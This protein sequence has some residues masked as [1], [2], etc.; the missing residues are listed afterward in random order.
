MKNFYERSTKYILGA[1]S[2]NDETII[3]ANWVDIKDRCHAKADSVLHFV[4]KF[5]HILNFTEDQLN[6]FSEEFIDYAC[7]S[8]KIMPTHIWKD[9]EEVNKQRD[10]SEKAYYMDD[11]LRA[12]LSELKFPG[13]GS[14]R[15]KLLSKVARLVLVLPHSNASSEIIFSLV[16]KN[17]T[18]FRP[19][20]SM[21]KTLG[22][23]LSVRTNQKVPCY[24]FQPPPSL[25]KKAKK[26]LRSTTNNTLKS[27]RQ[28]PTQS[29]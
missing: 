10:D 1:F 4:E 27:K 25:L 11:V 20:L 6:I 23:V 19:S 17:K 22:S 18:V 16:K 12:F 21:D 9:A 28:R 15:F 14:L 24:K 26:A 13:T 2:F 7:L 29:T 3:N 5:Q 8:D